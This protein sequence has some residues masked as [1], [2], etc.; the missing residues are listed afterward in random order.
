MTS[1]Q[2]DSAQEPHWRN[3]KLPEPFYIKSVAPIRLVSRE[4]RERALAAARLNL[5]NLASRDVFIDLL[6][7][8]GTGAM[9][10]NQWAALMQGDEAYAGS[11]S[12]EHFKAAVTG[13]FGFEYVL[14]SHQGRSAELVLMTHFLHAGDMVPSNIH[15]DTTSAHVQFQRALEINLV[16]DVIYDWDSELPFKGDMDLDKLEVFLAANADKVPLVTLTL[17]CNSGGGQPVSVEN[18]AAVKAICE[19]YGKPLLLDSARIIENAYFNQQRNPA[20]RNQSVL[21]ILLETMSHADGMW[22]SA[23]KDGLVNIGGFIAVRSRELYE[24][25]RIYSILFDGFCT[26]GGQAGRDLEALAVGLRECCEEDYL[27]HRT[28]QVAHLC[29]TLRDAGIR[30]TWPPGGHA[31]YVDGRDFCPHLPP[32]QFPAHALTLALY[33]EAGVRSVEIGTILRGR[34]PE[35]GENIYAGLDLVRMAIPRRTYSFTQLEYVA[36][37]LIQLKSKASSIR[38]VRFTRESPVLRHFTSE[39]DYL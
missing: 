3:A 21:E 11:A 23:K 14:P 26:Y 29:T 27:Q 38:G 24:Q 33:L 5:F 16:D 8:S 30:T 7:D 4:Q 18:V 34:H 36:D 28:C 13:L 20:R 6:T 25:L 1:E 22:M 17:T 39:F 9:S 32:E 19:K 10:Q 35:S 15:F 31:V 37:S 12:F 2:P